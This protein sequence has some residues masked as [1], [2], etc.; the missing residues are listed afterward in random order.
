MRQTQQQ[1]ILPLLDCLENQGGKVHTRDL[2]EAVATKCSIPEEEQARTIHLNGR[3]VNV[4][5]RSVRWAQQRAKLMGLASPTGRGEWVLTGKGKDALRQAA[6]GI[7]ITIFTTSMGVAL[8]GRAEEAVAHIED[9]SVNL[10]M[11]SPP[12]PLLREKQYGNKHAAEYLDWLMRIAE[13]WPRKI[14]RDGSIVLNLGD[15]WNSGEPTLSL[16]QER[17]LVRLEDELG[18]KLCMRYAWH[19]PAKM[20]APAEWVTVRRVRVKPSLEQLYWLAP[21]DEPY[22]DNRNVLVPYSEAMKS[23]IASGGENGGLRPSGHQLAAGAFDMDNGGAI[24]GNLII[25]SNTSSNSAYIRGCREQNLPVHPARFPR[26]LPEHFIKLTTKPGHTV[27]DPFCGSLQTGEVA[28]DL[29]RHW[30]GSD[31]TLEYLYG[32]ATRFPNAQFQRGSM[33]DFRQQGALF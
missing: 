20:P 15:A 17:L 18:W 23:R 27:Y 4:Y 8:F 1:I 22:A 29:G 14:A 5:Q 31:Y 32:A 33:N 2:Y 10:L 21:N 19:N 28:E 13:K 7:V 12:Y 6:P 25:A 30:I 16:Y 9:G 3:E 24:P 26:E 11:T